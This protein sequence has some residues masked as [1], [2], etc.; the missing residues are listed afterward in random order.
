ML[1]QVDRLADTLASA[2]QRG[3]IEKTLVLERWKAAETRLNSVEQN[4]TII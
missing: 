2:V 3:E 1:L 4:P